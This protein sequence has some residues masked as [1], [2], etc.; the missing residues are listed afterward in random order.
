MQPFAP[1]LL[2]E[3]EL[4]VDALLGTGLRSAVREDWRR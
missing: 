1:E 2:R 4:I 3:G